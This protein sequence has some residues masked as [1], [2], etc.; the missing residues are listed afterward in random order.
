[1]CIVVSCSVGLIYLS[2]YRVTSINYTQHLRDFYT[3][4]S[5]KHGGPPTPTKFPV[6]AKPAQCLQGARLNDQLL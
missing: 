5:S 1:M 3:I 6:F 2:Q 4:A